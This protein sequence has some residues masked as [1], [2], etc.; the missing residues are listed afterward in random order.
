MSPNVS[1]FKPISVGVLQGSI[2]GPILFNSILAHDP[3][4][5]DAT[6]IVL[7]IIFRF[8]FIVNNITSFRLLLENDFRLSIVRFFQDKRKTS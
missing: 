2:L 6:L 3:A 1:P 5:I 4:V 7:E 8:W